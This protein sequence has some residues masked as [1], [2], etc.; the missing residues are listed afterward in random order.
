MK[1]TGLII[2]A[3]LAGNLLAAVVKPPAQIV[4]R[5]IPPIPA[6]LAEKVK[7]YLAARALRFQ[8]WHPVKK[9]MLLTQ[10]PKGGQVAQLYVLEKPLGKP[11]QLTRGPEPVR[12]A[13]YQPVDGRSLIFTRDVGGSE[14]YQIFHHD[15]ATGK[16]TRLTD[17]KNRHTGARWSPDGKRIAYFSPKRN[18]RD[19]DLY[20]VDPTR[21]G[22]GKLLAQLPGGGWWL[23][24]WSAN[25]EI[26]MLI[27]YISITNSRL[28]IVDARTGERSR[29]SPELKVEVS[30]RNARFDPQMRAVY[31]TCDEDS[32]FQHIIR[33]DLKTGH[34]KRMLGGVKWDVEA[35]ELSPDGRTLA[36]VH[37]Q[38]GASN[39]RFIGAAS[40]KPAARFAGTAALPIG[41]I[42]SLQWHRTGAGLVYDIEWALSP[43]TIRTLKAGQKEPTSWAVSDTAQLDLN[44]IS[45]PRH[46]RLRSVDGV[47]FDSVVYAPGRMVN[48]KFIPQKSARGRP[49]VILF[50]GGPESQ[51][52]PRFMGRF[53]YLMSG[54]DMIL[55]C[56]N[57]RGSRGY[58]KKFLKA[59]NGKGRATVMRDIQRLRNAIGADDS[60]DANRIAVMGGSY[61]GFMTLHS[62][63]VLNNF[64]KCGV[65]VVGI[66]NFVTFL[67]NTSD[68]RRD[69]R[70]VEYGD[71]RDPKMRKF[72]QELSP[73]THVNEITRPL[74]IV[75]GAN[76]PRVP[77]SESEQMEKAL[78]K[79]GIETWYLLAKDEGHGFRKQSNREFQ[80]LT[81]IQFLRKHLLEQE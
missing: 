2:G 64:V 1:Q 6:T 14:R 46:W 16:T 38:E 35:F 50:H 27:E 61:G 53:N 29:F 5:G 13:Q 42:R 70:R 78:R 31:Y 60:F 74:L 72:L 43:G 81:T 45:H 25:G 9:H 58:G 63:V 75:Q 11:R 54:E 67:K 76:D 24:D 37:N 30:Y 56:P 26:M 40:G 32:D 48:G 66:S 3:L 18:E 33:L 8:D 71:E 52:R 41:V 69:L 55:V 47:E 23:A 51:F 36:V 17:G 80:F 68:Y 12:S 65:D 19:I 21:P 73:L 59:D 15:L 22:S 77:A 20:V 28:H 39:L 49:V 4:T 79:N 7:P 57:V 44:Q 34:R 62:M 10:R